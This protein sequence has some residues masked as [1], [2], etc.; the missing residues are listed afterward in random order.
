MIATVKFQAAILKNPKSRSHENI[1]QRD[2]RANT[3]TSS[4]N[5]LCPKFAFRAEGVLPRYT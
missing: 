4:R 1:V 2:W 3:E 5:N